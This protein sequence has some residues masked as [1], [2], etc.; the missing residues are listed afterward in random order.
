MTFKPPERI[1]LQPGAGFD[2]DT[3]WCVDQIEDDDI[4]YIRANKFPPNMCR[5]DHQRV[6][7][8]DEGEGIDERCPMCRMRNEYEAEIERLKQDLAWASQR[9]VHDSNVS[10]YI[11]DTDQWCDGPCY[12]EEECKHGGLVCEVCA[13]D[14]ERRRIAQELTPG[15][16][17]ELDGPIRTDLEEA[18]RIV[19]GEA[20]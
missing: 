7:Y 20:Q 16:M 9:C 4:E 18:L 6:D 10:H 8:R 11:G 19:E 13:T 15:N 2:G 3:T 5:I 12:G 17:D 14:R 1:W